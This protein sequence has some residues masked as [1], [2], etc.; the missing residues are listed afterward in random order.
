MVSF[1]EKR[2]PEF[3]AAGSG[4]RRVELG[5]E[6]RASA[7]RPPPPRRRPRPPRA[8]SSAEPRV[9]AAAPPP[10]PRRRARA[11]AFERGHLLLGVLEEPAQRARRAGLRRGRQLRRRA[12][13]RVEGADAPARRS[14]RRDARRPT[15][16]SRPGDGRRP[17]LAVEHE[18]VGDRALEEGAVVAHDDERAGPVVEEVLERA[19]RVEVEVVGRLVEQ[20]HVRLLRQR[21]QQLHPPALAARQ[22]ADRRPLRVVVEPERLEQAGVG[23]V[24]LAG[25]PGDRLPHPLRRVERRAALVVERELHGRARARPR[26]RAGLAPPGDHV[27]QRRLAGAVRARRCR[28]ARAGRGAGRGRGTASA[29]P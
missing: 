16:R 4:S 24:R 13:R 26:P 8:P 6:R 7:P 12:A 9:V 27:E 23:P 28:A 25:G 15:R 20:Q 18:H 3:R 5:A 2:P 21:E 14:V 10:P 22:Q 29:S 19:Q 11:R 1:L 17:G